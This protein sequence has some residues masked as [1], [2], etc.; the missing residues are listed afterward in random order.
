MKGLGVSVH[1]R[2]IPYG[3]MSCVYFAG[4]DMSVAAFPPLLCR[5]DPRGADPRGLPGVWRQLP[6]PLQ[7]RHAVEV[8]VLCCFSSRVVMVG[9]QFPRR[10]VIMSISQEEVYM[11]QVHFLVCAY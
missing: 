1:P 5:L 4:C 6:P 2:C 10:S 11:L 8:R 3:Y 7:H 9:E